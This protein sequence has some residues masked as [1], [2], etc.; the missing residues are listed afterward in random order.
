MDEGI[1]PHDW[2]CANISPVFKKGNRNLADNYQPVSLTSQIYKLFESIIRDAL[3]KHLEENK[4]LNDTQHGFK[5]GRSCLTNL[6]SFMDKVAGCLDSGEPV[7][8]IFLDFAKAFDK[9]PYQKLAIKLEAHGVTGKLLKWIVNWLEG[10]K[11]R[12]CINGIKSI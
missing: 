7:D 8:A 5:K 10:R 12:V 2:K 3:V 11:Q 1:V 9:V 4:S 6:L